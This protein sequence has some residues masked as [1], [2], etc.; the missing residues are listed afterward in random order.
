MSMDRMEST[1]AYLMGN[2]HEGGMQT[3]TWHVDGLTVARSPM[4]ASSHGRAPNR[5][6]SVHVPLARPGHQRRLPE[7]LVQHR[8]ARGRRPSHGTQ[9]AAAEA[10]VPSARKSTDARLASCPPRGAYTDRAPRAGNAAL[11]PRAQA[12]CPHPSECRR[13]AGA[14]ADGD[15]AARAEREYGT[16]ARG[17]PESGTALILTGRHCRG[18]VGA[19][20]RATAQFACTRS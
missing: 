1:G 10:D 20:G 9:H 17:R 8:N 3:D 16:A 7:R 13:R 6:R 5:K 19:T 2:V 14:T 12:C 15:S 11:A 18:G 4:P